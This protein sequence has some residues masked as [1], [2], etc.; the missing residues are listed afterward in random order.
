MKK[1]IAVIV[2]ASILI[3]TLGA[4]KGKSG[5]DASG[6]SGAA[7][8]KGSLP[9]VDKKTQLRVFLGESGGANVV[10]SYAYADNAFTKRVTDET[11]IEFVW[12]IGSE[13]NKREQLNVLLSAGD[14][15][16]VLIADTLSY[17]DLVYYAGQGI[18][19]SLDEFED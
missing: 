3:L 4:C 2:L 15:P 7:R 11:N 9:L 19:R 10:S 8:V 16:E 6:S 13:S 14:Y 5:G 18:L 17:S 1:R 12:T